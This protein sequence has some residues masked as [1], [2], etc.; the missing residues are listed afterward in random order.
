MLPP[1]SKALRGTLGTVVA[2]L[3]ATALTAPSLPGD[4]RVAQLAPAL[5][6]TKTV[7][8]DPLVIGGTAEYAVTVTNTGDEPAE[9]VVVTDTLGTGITAG[10]LPDG[11]EATGATVVC[12]GDGGVTVGPGESVT[13]TLPVEVD[14][15]LSDGDNIVNRAEA[16]SSTPGASPG[17]TQLITI[18]Q[19]QTDVEV[20]KSGPATVLPGGEIAYTVV[21]TNNG[22]SDAVDVTVQDPTNGNLVTITDLPDS[23]PPSGLTITCG[24]GTL[25]PGESVELTF[26]VEAG[27]EL[28][29][30]TTIDN[31]ATIYTGSRETD[32]NNNVSCAE[33][34]VDDDTGPPIVVPTD[35]V[36]IRKTGPET[37]APGGEV[38]YSVTVTNDGSEESGDVIVVDPIDVGEATPVVIPEQCTREGDTLVCDLGQLAAGE[39]AVLDF[40]F[41]ADGPPGDHIHNCAAV[42]QPT[43]ALDPDTHAVCVDT[44]IVDDDPDPSPTPSPTPTPT[45]GPTPTESPTE[46]PEPT[47]GPT[48][49]EGPGGYHPPDNGSDGDDPPA[50][51]LAGAPLFGLVMAALVLVGSGL[52]VLWTTRRRL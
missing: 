21:V 24:L 34:V 22:P 2:A 32:M 52:A 3:A 7:V 48:P 39:S 10:D 45:P 4:E 50:L 14:P 36:S 15:S 13:Y 12:G 9:D 25:A 46:S 49:T 51:A 18:A 28:D 19:T 17:S 43:R 33:T 16:T 6:V 38:T 26:V 1:I 5:Q 11:C 41:R 8:P 35:D 40:V 44:E 47:P 31:C 37:T 23:C 20:S 42:Q 29:E 30:G 27:P